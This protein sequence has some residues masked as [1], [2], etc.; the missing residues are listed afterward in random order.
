MAG[1]GDDADDG[2][3]GASEG[4]SERSLMCLTLDNPVRQFLLQLIS[5][6]A[7]DSVVLLAIGCN[8][9][10]MAMVRF[11]LALTGRLARSTHQGI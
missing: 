6:Q 7:F 2:G 10:M 3:A 4:Y 1:S 9:V 5:K 8:S 11:L